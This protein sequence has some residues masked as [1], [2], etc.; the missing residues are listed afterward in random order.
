M[1]EHCHINKA[2]AQFVKIVYYRSAHLLYYTGE[3][4]SLLSK[5]TSGRNW[6]IKRVNWPHYQSDRPKISCSSLTSYTGAP[7]DEVHDFIFYIFIFCCFF[8]FL[9]IKHQAGIFSHAI[10]CTWWW[11]ANLPTNKM[12]PTWAHFHDLVI[13]RVAKFAL[14]DSRCHRVC[15]YGQA[16]SINTII[17]PLRINSLRGYPMSCIH[18]I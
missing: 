6:A 2:Q 17:L 12:L 16:D 9:L 1:N 5:Q 3:P 8:L 15:F 14:F 13:G 18:A 7:S 4:H 11:V 10:R